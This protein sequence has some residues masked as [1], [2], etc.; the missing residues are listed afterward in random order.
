[1]EKT[2]KERYSAQTGPCFGQ[3]DEA[4][5]Q[6]GDHGVDGPAMP[7]GQRGLRAGLCPD[8]DD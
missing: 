1:M 6:G 5:T 3:A 4:S 7:Q 8:V 2:T